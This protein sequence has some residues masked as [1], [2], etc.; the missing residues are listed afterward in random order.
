MMADFTFRAPALYDASATAEDT[1]DWVFH[2]SP[3]AS[4]QLA[5]AKRFA[6]WLKAEMDRKGLGTGVPE[7]DES[8]WM[9]TVPSEGGFILCIVSVDSDGETP[10]SL[11]VAKIGDSQK[12][13]PRT[14]AAIEAIL[15][16]AGEVSELKVDR[17]A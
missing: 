6:F 2:D 8:G 1:L 15:R 17:D 3:E 13:Y 12:D 9:I 10:F 5:K 4:E 7:M 11:T 16:A 14:V